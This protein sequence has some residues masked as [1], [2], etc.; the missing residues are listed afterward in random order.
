[1]LDFRYPWAFKVIARAVAQRRRT[2]GQESTV[3]MRSGRRPCG[4]QRVRDTR[5]GSGTPC[6]YQYLRGTSSKMQR[7]T[8]K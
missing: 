7:L 3:S 1:M 4:R 6:C 2:A 5:K 8:E